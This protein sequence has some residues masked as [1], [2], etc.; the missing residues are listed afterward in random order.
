MSSRKNSTI[1]SLLLA[2]GLL[3]AIG[4]AS[5]GL[6][7]RSLA[8]EAQPATKP[9]LAI[10]PKPNLRLASGLSPSQRFARDLEA[11]QAAIVAH[12]ESLSNLQSAHLNFITFTRADGIVVRWEYNQQGEVT[13]L[14]YGTLSVRMHVPGSPHFGYDVKGPEVNSDTYIPWLGTRRNSFGVIVG[15]KWYPTNLVGGDYYGDAQDF[16]SASLSLVSLQPCIDRCTYLKDVENVNCTYNHAVCI[17]NAR[18]GLGQC[19]ATVTVGAAL[20]GAGVGAAAGSAVAGVGAIPG[21]VLGG[22]GGAALG[23]LGCTIAFVAAVDSCDGIR[24][25]CFARQQSLFDLC[26]GRCHTTSVPD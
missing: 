20:A 19:M 26:V 3:L 16:T 18:A 14:H 25:A 23:S 24:D 2:A 9:A 21:A 15:V 22:M 17:E 4:G 6:T 10:P 8:K 5:A 12:G 1:F 7:S 11:M 13:H